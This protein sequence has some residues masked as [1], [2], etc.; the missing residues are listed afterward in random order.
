MAKIKGICK[1]YDEDC[2]LCNAKVVQE[3]EKEEFLCSECG[4]PLSPVEGGG[5]SQKHGGSKKRI[6]LIAGC[7]VILGALGCLG[8]LLFSSGSGADK[9]PLEELKLSETELKLT[10]GDTAL[11]AVGRVPE[12]TTD[13]TLIW[14]TSDAKVATIDGGL[15]RALGSG[16]ATLTVTN[17]D[18]AIA[19]TLTVTVSPAAEQNPADKNVTGEGK[20]TSS[21]T[22]TQANPETTTT[23]PS[24]PKQ[25]QPAVPGGGSSTSTISVTTPN[26]SNNLQTCLN[27]IVNKSISKDQRLAMIPE[28]IKKHFAP[29]AKV[30]TLGDNDMIVDYEPVN[31]FLRRI[32]LSNRISQITIVDQD[33]SHKHSEIS[34]YEN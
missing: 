18:R 27:D 11:I 5:G 33:L 30:K 34:I 12:N 3:A 2:S 10:E 28:I 1:N 26:V 6:L 4:K 29:D 25:T 9:I 14:C 21:E 20:E 13:T 24:P 15:L 23:P 16:N 31:T 7:V 8:W 32:A 17:P 22:N 19:A